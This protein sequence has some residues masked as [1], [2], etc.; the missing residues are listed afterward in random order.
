[1]WVWV[2]EVGWGGC[3]GGFVKEHDREGGEKGVGMT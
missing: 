3:V 1:L 2:R